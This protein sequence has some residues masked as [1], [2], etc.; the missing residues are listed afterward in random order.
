MKLTQRRHSDRGIA[1]VIVLVC[2][3]VLAALAAI[4]AA[5]MKVETRIAR[6]SKHGAEKQWRGGPRGVELARYFLAQQWLIPNEPYDA[7][8]QKWA[9][10]NGETN[11]LLAD[12][13]LPDVPLGDGKFSVKIT[14]TERKFNINLALGNDALLQQAMILIGVDAAEIPTII[15]SIQDWIDR[16][17]N[18]RVNAAESEYY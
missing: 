5:Y 12:I 16:D 13:T 9:G 17:D 10:G 6:D 18:T 4:F 14:D 2:V 7:L 3:F 11:S 8:N 1:I 15:A